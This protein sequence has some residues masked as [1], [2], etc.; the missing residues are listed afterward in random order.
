VLCYAPELGI[1][2]FVRFVSKGDDGGTDSDKG[3]RDDGD[4]STRRDPAAAL[5]ADVQLFDRVP[6]RLDAALSPYRRPQP[7]MAV[8]AAPT[9]SVSCASSSPSRSVSGT[10]TLPVPPPAT[11]HAPAPAPV[12]ESLYSLMESFAELAL[13][14]EEDRES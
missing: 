8:A 13:H 7:T 14:V 4:G 11:Q 2:C 12:P 5:L 9:R 3:D 1:K 6:V 10:H